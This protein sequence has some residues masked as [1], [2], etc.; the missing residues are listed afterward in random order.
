MSSRDA[1]RT[2]ARLSTQQTRT[3]PVEILVSNPTGKLKPGFFAKGT[4]L[5][6]KDE[7]VLAVPQEAVSTL[8]GVSSVFV[9]EDG[10]VRQQNVTLG[11][12]EG[13]FYEI[14]D[15]LKGN[16]DTGRQQSQRNHDGNEGHARQ[17]PVRRRRRVTSKP[18]S[19]VAPSRAYRD[20]MG[21]EAQRRR[22]ARRRRQLVK[23]ADVSIRRP[24]FA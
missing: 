18:P 2:S 4:I 23:I 21:S 12:Q 24:V 16:G 14:M 5:T 22:P 19:E 17:K 8:A 13:N 6:Q 15:G 7:N 9:I 3:F 1:F 10:A 11:V 20:R